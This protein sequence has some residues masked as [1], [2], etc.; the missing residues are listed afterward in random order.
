MNG[1][2]F[3][4]LVEN[5]LKVN[6]EL[7]QIQKVPIKFPNGMVLTTSSVHLIEAI[8]QHPN[9]NLTELADILGVTKGSLS[10]QIPKLITNNLITKYR[11]GENKKNYYFCLTELGQEIVDYHKQLHRK[12]YTSL[13]ADMNELKIEDAQVINNM[14]TR[15]SESIKTYQKELRP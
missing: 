7:T 15:I 1:N 14:Y 3:M 4:K 2:E 10:Q 8:G 13:L 12:L 5:F 9:T 11:N 6:N